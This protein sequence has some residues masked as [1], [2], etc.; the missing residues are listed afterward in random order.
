MSRDGASSRVEGNENSPNTNCLDGKRCPTC[1]SY[2]PFEIEVSM[3]VLLYDSGADDAKD[4]SIEYDDESF[5]I[6]DECGYSA[7]FGKFNQK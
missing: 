7:E 5:A 4:G 6:C 1:G 2:G 3:R